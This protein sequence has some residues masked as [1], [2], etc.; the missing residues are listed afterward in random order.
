MTDASHSSFRTF[1]PAQEVGAVPPQR[2]AL[3][4]RLRQGSPIG[5][6]AAAPVRSYDPATMTPAATAPA[7]REEG[8]RPLSQEEL[9]ERAPPRPEKL[10]PAPAPKAAL[11]HEPEVIS[12]CATQPIGVVLEIAGSGSQI[13]IDLQR[14]NECMD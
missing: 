11:T 12:E 4:D 10:P 3:R 6:T 5:D 1:D 9:A 2:S 13:A 7:P 14:L 8:L